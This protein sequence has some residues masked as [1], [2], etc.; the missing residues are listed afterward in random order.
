MALYGAA[1]RE[2][3]KVLGGLSTDGK[4]IE[5]AAMDTDENRGEE[6]TVLFRKLGLAV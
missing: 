4:D 6:D 3:F 1:F 5:T 2:T